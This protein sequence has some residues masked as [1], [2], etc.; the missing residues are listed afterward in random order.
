MTDTATLSVAELSSSLD[1][2]TLL[3]L[4][5]R[6]PA[7][8]LPFAEMLFDRIRGERD[9]QLSESSQTAEL[10]RIPLERLEGELLDNPLLVEYFGLPEEEEEMD[11]RLTR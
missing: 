9:D 3:Y 4:P 6:S 10:I 11:G 2:L 1:L 7:P 8:T 5:S